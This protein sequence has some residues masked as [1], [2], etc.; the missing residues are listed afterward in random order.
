MHYF[1]IKDHI[2]VG[3]KTLEHSPMGNMLGDRFIKP[4]QGSIFRK[5][6]A[7]IKGIPY[8]TGELD[9]SWGEAGE[10]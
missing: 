9:I 2:L 1:L 6:R 3:E 10:P 7:E 4:L 5:Y 8:D